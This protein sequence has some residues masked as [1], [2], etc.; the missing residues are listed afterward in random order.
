MEDLIEEYKAAESPDYVTWGDRPASVAGTV[1][2]SGAASLA[3]SV[4]ETPRSLA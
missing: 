3:A 1:A 2:G 4:A